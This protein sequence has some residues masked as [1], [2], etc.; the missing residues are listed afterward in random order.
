M[1][2]GRVIW[3]SG[4]QVKVDRTQKPKAAGDRQH[5][6]GQHLELCPNCILDDFLKININQEGWQIG[7]HKWFATVWGAGGKQCIIFSCGFSTFPIPQ[8]CQ[9]HIT[10]IQSI[11]PS[12]PSRLSPLG[13]GGGTILCRLSLKPIPV[14]FHF[15]ARSLFSPRPPSLQRDPAP[16]RRRDR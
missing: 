15:P 4:L 5:K 2:G 10:S 16:G 12:G 1:A 3:R 8:M 6:S 13:L 9:C 14:G 7:W 11:P